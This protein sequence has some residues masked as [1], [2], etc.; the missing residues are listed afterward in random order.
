MCSV[1]AFKNY[2]RILKLF[3]LFSF[4]FKTARYINTQGKH[5]RT[6]ESRQLLALCSNLILK[7]YS[8][9]H[10]LRVNLRKLEALLNIF[11][12]KQKIHSTRGIYCRKYLIKR[13]SIYL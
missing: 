6:R 3:V 2:F 12:R 10:S 8:E 4:R 13:Q 11:R 5:D 7:H 9:I 1:S